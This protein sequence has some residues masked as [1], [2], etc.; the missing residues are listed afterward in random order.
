MTNA[1]QF[2][3][4]KVSRNITAI[5]QV[6]ISPIVKKAPVKTKTLPLIFIGVTSEIYVAER[7]DIMPTEIPNKSL[8]IAKDWKFWANPEMSPK[9][10]LKNTP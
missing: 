8:K 3:E 2:P 7:G 5:K 9:K 4:E 1:R 10:K 6:I